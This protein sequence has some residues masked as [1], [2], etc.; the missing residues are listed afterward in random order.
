MQRPLPF[1]LLLFAPVL[2]PA[3]VTLHKLL[4]KIPPPPRG[5]ATTP[6][7]SV[8]VLDNRLD[9][10]FVYTIEDGHYPV[11]R[12]SFAG[13][14]EQVLEGCMQGWLNRLTRGTDDLL[15]NIRQ[16]SIPNDP[17]LGMVL[18]FSADA[19]LRTPEGLYQK[20]VHV[21]RRFPYA[22]NGHTHA[23]AR[24]S[25]ELLEVAGIARE[26]SLGRPV[27]VRP[28][29]QK[30]F[31]DTHVYTFAPP[32]NLVYPDQI[33]RQR[34]VHPIETS[35]DTA[36]GL[37][38]SFADFRDNHLLS[39]SVVFRPDP[40][41]DSLYRLF[42]RD[43][44]KDLRCLA[45]PWAVCDGHQLFIRLGSAG[46]LPLQRDPTGFHFY[47]PWSV[48][49]RYAQLCRFGAMYADAETPTSSGPNFSGGDF[50]GM[51]AKG[52]LIFACVFIV[53]GVGYEIALG[54]HQAHLE[55]LEKRYDR[56]GLRQAYRYCTVD[57]QSGDI[58]FAS[59]GY[60]AGW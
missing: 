48:P 8:Q 40:K 33:G 23:I 24:V 21:S 9:T 27:T 25:T 6:F 10:S 60:P 29:L 38:M 20:L 35:L 32:G 51:D 52:A 11:R 5:V 45:T 15:V 57:M 47:I 59:E 41:A 42:I 7:R 1:F 3:Q 44:A 16:L 2:S 30:K 37:Y 4:L 56:L 26:Q 54:A 13:P 14:A 39:A 43:N 28:A 36:A 58:L 22:R 12:V 18:I 31:R 49:D 17:D 53:V 55:H 34:R 50:S 19:Y 46:Y